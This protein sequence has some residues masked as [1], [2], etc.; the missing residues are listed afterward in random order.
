MAKQASADRTSIVL[1]DNLKKALTELLVL[2]LIEE[3][4]RYIGELSPEIEERSRGVIHIEFPYAAI[5]RISKAEYI[6]ECQ[7]KVAPDGRLRQYYTITDKGRAYLEELRSSYSQ[8][9][10]AANQVMTPGFS[11]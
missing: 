7:K 8:F 10:Q 5:Y 3:Q 11:A 9:I 4:D 6:A 2:S 1:E